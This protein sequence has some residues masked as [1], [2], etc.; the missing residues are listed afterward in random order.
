MGE[1]INT[2][3]DET[4]AYI[5]PAEGR[6][7]FASNG[8]FNMGGFDIF[9]CEREVD[10]SW[11]PATNIGYPINTTGDNLQFVPLNDGL[12]GLYT[13][14][15]DDAIGLRDLWYMEILNE[16]G[17]VE[18]GLTLA[19]DKQGISRNDFA[20]ILVDEESGDEIE[21]LYD[22]ETDTFQALPSQDKSYKVISYKQ[23]K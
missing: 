12:S 13:R 6:F 9:R 18:E 23:Q 17:F 8:H 2:D 19:V 11:G 20:I 5:A 16:D 21:V 3:R 22:A 7:L 14:F 1:A 4:S 10:G 15:S